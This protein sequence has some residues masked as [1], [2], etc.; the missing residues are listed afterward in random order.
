MR[1]RAWLG[2]AVAVA[3][4][5]AVG[6][7]GGLFTGASIASGWYA[8]LVK[9]ALM[10]PAW[11]FAPVWTALYA[12]MG[13]AAYLVWRA[14][15]RSRSLRFIALW[16][17]ALQL[18]ANTLWS[19]LFFGAQSPGLAL[20]DIGVLWLLIAATLVAFSR[21]SRFAAWLLAPYL[22]WATFAA[23]LNLAIVLLN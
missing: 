16:L 2:L 7:I 18:V 21:I 6:L 14:Y 15:E 9:P 11:V 20:L 1:S 3:I 8:T 23:Y 19:V 12:L 13:I 22:A 17:F 5:E 10:P 4:S